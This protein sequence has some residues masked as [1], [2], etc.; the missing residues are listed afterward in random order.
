MRKT[1]KIKIKANPNFA[2]IVDGDTE[3]W[4]F[5]MLKRNER[6]INVSIEPK[7]P[8]KKSLSEQFDLACFLSED[9]TTVFWIIDFDTILKETKEAKKGTETPLQAF[10][11][12]RNTIKSKYKNVV[13]IVNNPCL[14]FWILLHF[15]KSSKY[16]NSCGAVEKYLKKYLKDYQKSK[17]YY[18]KQDNDIYLKLRPYLNNAIKNAKHLGS[19]NKHEPINAMSEME[20]FYNA[21]EFKNYFDS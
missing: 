13:I 10:M 18:T 15:E 8:Q 3:V 11:K 14:E 17:K 7:I 20:L 16:Y 1:R 19:F 21:Q 12:Y 4:Y 2:I 6:K 5:Q 9:Y